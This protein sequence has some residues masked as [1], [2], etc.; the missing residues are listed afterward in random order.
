MLAG[1][2]LQTSPHSERTVDMRKTKVPVGCK[3]FIRTNMFLADEVFCT[4]MSEGEEFTE[5]IGKAR[6][7]L[8]YTDSVSNEKI[9]H[10]LAQ[11]YRVLTGIRV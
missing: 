9:R 2:S 11:Q 5:L 6:A 1:R 3:E 10:D 4:G 8:H 7:E